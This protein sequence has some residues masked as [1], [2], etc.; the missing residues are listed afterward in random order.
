MGRKSRRI[1]RKIRKKY[2]REALFRW[3]VRLILLVPMGCS[4]GDLLVY[5]NLFSPS[6][7]ILAVTL[8]I[9]IYLEVPL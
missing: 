1:I 4:V 2:Q 3:L 8:I 9:F 7:V 5:H 6:L